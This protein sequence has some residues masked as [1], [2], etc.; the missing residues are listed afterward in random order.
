M[1]SSKRLLVTGANGLLGYALRQIKPEACFVSRQDGD[2][3]NFDQTKRI[4]RKIQP[5]EIIHLAAETGGVKSN[6]EKNADYLAANLQINTNILAAAAQAGVKRLIALLCSCAFCADGNGKDLTEDDLHKGLPYEGNL[7][8]GYAKRALDIHI[9]LIA[10]QYGLSYNTLSPVTIFGPN[11]NWDPQTGHVVAALIAKCR[12]AEVREEPLI[13]WGTGEA[14][15]QFIY[16]PDMARLLLEALKN[17]NGPQT[18]IIAPDAGITIKEL[19]E[20]IAELMNFTGPVVFDAAKPQ[21]QLRKVLQ[22]RKFSSCFP[23]FRFTP[24]KDALTA[25]IEWFLMNSKIAEND[26]VVK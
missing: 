6:A 13:V 1:I 17:Y 10:R 9:R 21:G 3:T 19:A 4:I 25:T 12:Q 23:K 8:Y 15:R 5:T 7:G 20:Q 26:R 16:S 22:S 24:I 11:D 2:L 14:R 18:V